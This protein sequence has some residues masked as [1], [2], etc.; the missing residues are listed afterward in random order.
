MNEGGKV[1]ANFCWNKN[2][3][4]GNVGSIQVLVHLSEHV[5]GFDYSWIPFPQA[6]SFDKDK[7]WIPVHVN[8]DKGDISAGQ[9]DM[10]A[11]KICSSGP[12]VLAIR[13]F[14]AVKQDPVIRL[15]NPILFRI[16]Q[17][18]IRSQQN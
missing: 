16:Q 9:Q 7:E 14:Y 5:R 2:E 11:K 13:W 1:A 15:R 3:Y 6:A 12:L 8:N 4:K 17:N 10:A 18:I